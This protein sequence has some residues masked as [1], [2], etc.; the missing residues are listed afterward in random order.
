MTFTF[1]L[2]DLLLMF[3][4]IVAPTPVIGSPEIMVSDSAPRLVMV[5]GFRPIIGEILLSILLVIASLTRGQLAM[6]NVM[7]GLIRA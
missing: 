6:D 4:V 7:E 1:T 2:Q 5:L 3:L